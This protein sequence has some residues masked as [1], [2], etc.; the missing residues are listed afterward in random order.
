MASNLVHNS[1][2]WW[3]R[4]R[5]T[6][7]GHGGLESRLE[8]VRRNGPGRSMFPVL[9]CNICALLNIV[10]NSSV[11]V[12]TSMNASTRF[13]TSVR[14]DRFFCSHFAVLWL[15]RFGTT[16]NTWCT[17]GKATYRNSSGRFHCIYRSAGVIIALGIICSSARTVTGGNRR[18]AAAQI[19]NRSAFAI[20]NAPST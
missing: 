15:C 1:S 16:G 20:I 13:D 11:Y 4:T 8:V 2:T 6:M 18:R 9:C 3:R 19:A 5:H 10:R 7:D 17:P 12:A 14:S